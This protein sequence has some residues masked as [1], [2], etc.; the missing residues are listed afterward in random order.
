MLQAPAV[1]FF[2]SPVAPCRAGVGSRPRVRRCS[3]AW[4]LAGSILELPKEGRQRRCSKATAFLLLK[5]NCKPSLSNRLL[6]L[7]PLR[8]GA[9]NRA[10]L[11]PCGRGTSSGGG[12]SASPS[13]FLKEDSPGSHPS[14]P[15]SGSGRLQ[16]L[17][18]SP[19]HEHGRD[20]RKAG[21]ARRCP[22]AAE[23]ARLKEEALRAALLPSPS[24][25]ALP[26][27]IGLPCSSAAEHGLKSALSTVGRHPLGYPGQRATRGPPA[28]SAASERRLRNS[29]SNWP[30]LCHQRGGHGEMGTTAQQARK[31]PGAE[32]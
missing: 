11:L 14:A 9:K 25:H 28:V 22:W 2:P 30:G 19:C 31:P 5:P 10:P 32:N 7:K 1:S 21:S 4:A 17:R 29:S 24:T 27:C 6:R 16:A 23:V 26:W 12:V 15:R 13:R 8:P 3:G 18:C 20:G